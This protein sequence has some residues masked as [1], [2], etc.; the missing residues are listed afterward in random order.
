MSFFYFGRWLKGSCRWLFK[1]QW[2]WRAGRWTQN[3]TVGKTLTS[4][5]HISTT[6]PENKSSYTHSIPP[7]HSQGRVRLHTSTA[8]CGF[9]AMKFLSAREKGLALAWRLNSE[10]SVI[11]LL[12]T[13]L[14]FYKGRINKSELHTALHS[15]AFLLCPIFLKSCQ[16][17]TWEWPHLHKTTILIQQPNTYFNQGLIFRSVIYI[18]TP[19]SQIWKPKVFLKSRNSE[20][21][22]WLGV[23]LVFHILG[24]AGSKIW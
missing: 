10:L 1:T 13:I 19:Q 9:C 7:C 17:F 8:C 23:C 2:W 18:H 4:S 6:S 14:H 22:H 24:K 11:S 21:C 12:N 16:D 5:K 3:T 15:S 20:K